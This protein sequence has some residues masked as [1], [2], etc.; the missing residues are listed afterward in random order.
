MAIDNP[1]VYDKFVT[2]KNFIGRREDCSILENLLT[3]GE[4]IALYGPPKS[5]KMS[6]IQQT[7]FNMR[8]AGKRFMVGQ[9]S[10]LNVRSVDRFLLRYGATAM[11][12]VAQTP[13]EFAGIVERH[14]GGSHFVFDPARY[15]QDDEPVSAGWALD[16]TDRRAM[17]SLPF[18][19]A[20]ESAQPL[21]LIMD[22]FERLNDLEGGEDV[23]RTLESIIREQRGTQPAC[24]L[25]F[26]GSMNNA[27]K[28]IFEEKRFFWRLAER[29][30]LR[31][32]DEKEIIDYV[33][34]GF[35]SS[36]KVVERE[37]L[38][39]MCRLF[40]NNLWYINHFINICDGLSKGYIVE[41]TLMEAL[42]CLLAIHEPRFMATMADLTAYQINFLQAVLERN[43]KFTATSV[44]SKY[45]LSSSA[46][47]KRLRE[48]LLKKEI[49]T[50]NEQGEAVMLDPL[51][52]YWVRKYYYEID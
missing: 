37:L 30:S 16:E 47:V 41:S 5:G 12:T 22:E 25:L 52:E 44:R 24:S 8:I 19:L 28:E 45:G 31:T 14:L 17:L 21:F 42:G 51:F 26:C 7:L 48:A 39:G 10:L 32:V 9:F 29:L 13:A 18:A 49:I 36:G 35:L 20:R 6:V 23:F 3:Q 38:L 1:F 46:N 40:R 15:S 50:F 34:R 43:T 11:R 27:M 2:G 4:H 33:V